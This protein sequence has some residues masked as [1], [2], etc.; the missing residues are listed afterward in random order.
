MDLKG[1]VKIGVLMPTS[2]VMFMGEDFFSGIENRISE[3]HDVQLIKY[4]IGFGDPI[5]VKE[6][7]KT[8]I[9]FDNV[10]IITG[11]LSEPI[12]SENS[13][14]IKSH[15]TVG[16]F[17][18]FGEHESSEKI[19]NIKIIKV[20]LSKQVSELTSWAVTKFGKNGMFVGGIYEAGYAFSAM[21]ELGMMNA[22]AKNYSFHINASLDP[23]TVCI[24]EEYISKIKNDNPDFIF[25]AFNGEEASLFLEA[26]V[27]AKLH[28]KIPIISL[29]YIAEDFFNPKK[30]QITIY[31]SIQLN[32]ENHQLYNPW[33]VFKYLGNLVAK[34][35]MDLCMLQPIF[36]N[37]HSD[38]MFEGIKPEQPEEHTFT[39]HLLKINTKGNKDLN[40]IEVMNRLDTLKLK[41][42]TQTQFF[43]DASSDWLSPYLGI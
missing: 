4:N 39:N 41:K 42:H 22:K 10:D 37:N 31:S 23:E 25:G 28:K 14:Y 36:Q 40:K 38:T 24:S 17:C 3:L 27:Q 5:S 20:D 8:A 30:E 32:D 43:N 2:S 1:Y 34:S 16:I 9:E 18:N 6:T 19:D 21:F 15:D 7:L 33:E 12:I 35:V 29:P 11:I 26:F 13:D